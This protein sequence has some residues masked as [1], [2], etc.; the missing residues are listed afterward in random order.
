MLVLL[1][2]K[3]AVVDSVLDE[4]TAHYSTAPS[5]VSAGGE[6][7]EVQGAVVSSSCFQQ[8]FPAARIEA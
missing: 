8:L 1:F 5:Y 7:G 6:T 4:L 3:F 2:H